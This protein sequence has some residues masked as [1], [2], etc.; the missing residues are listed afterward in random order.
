MGVITVLTDAT[1]MVN[2]VPKNNSNSICVGDDSVAWHVDSGDHLIT[3]LSTNNDVNDFGPI[4]QIVGD[5]FKLLTKA[6]EKPDVQD[7][8]KQMTAVPVKLLQACEHV[9]ML[10]RGRCI[11]LMFC[12]SMPY[13]GII[14]HLAILAHSV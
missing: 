4:I 9:I 7:E 8:F 11:F 10:H 12:K 2:V 14:V 1:W 3:F 6:G 5:T 13:N